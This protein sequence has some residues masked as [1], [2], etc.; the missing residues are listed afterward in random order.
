MV[1]VL[2]DIHGNKRRF[3]S[4]MKQINLQPDDKLY[5]LGDVV[6][7]HPYGIQILR[8][9]MAMPNAEMLLGNHESMMLDALDQPY[10]EKD[11]REEDEHQRFL[12]QWYRNGGDVTHNYLKRLK[13][14]LRKEIFAYLRQLPL[15]IDVQVNEKKYK[16]CHGAPIEMFGTDEYQRY[17]DEKEFAIWYRL[18]EFDEYPPDCIVIHGHTPTR[19]YQ[20]DNPLSIY[21][22]ENRIAIDCG[23]GYPD[24]TYRKREPKGRLACLRLDDMREFYSKELPSGQQEEGK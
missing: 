20:L 21:Y 9:I 1:Y 14:E 16:L 6:D 11:W 10:N 22:G 13:K 23:C 3:D 19:H 7:R 24:I 17:D 8:Q 2:S 18:R 12:Y 5:V 4:I 15:N